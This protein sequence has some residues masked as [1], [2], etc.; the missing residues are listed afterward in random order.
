[1]T[2]IILYYDVIITP[3]SVF[4]KDPPLGWPEKHRNC[5]ISTPQDLQRRL[6]GSLNTSLGRKPCGALAGIDVNHS[7]VLTIMLQQRKKH[8]KPKLVFSDSGSIRSQHNMSRSFLAV[9][10]PKPPCLCKWLANVCAMAVSMSAGQNF[11]P[12]LTTLSQGCQLKT[13]IQHLG[14]TWCGGRVY[15]SQLVSDAFLNARVDIHPPVTCRIFKQT[16]SLQASRS[17]GALKGQATKSDY[18][19]ILGG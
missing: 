4:R 6:G 2:L 12:L 3:G 17:N 10:H 15:H 8:H 19:V 5:V 13:S 18:D 1:M 11:Q 16:A 9:S 7:L 14:Q